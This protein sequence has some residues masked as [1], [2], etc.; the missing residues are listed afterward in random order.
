MTIII[1]GDSGDCLPRACLRGLNRFQMAEIHRLCCSP[2]IILEL[3]LE[4]SFG[5]PAEHF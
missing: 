1:E 5:R 3:E 4:P 2:E